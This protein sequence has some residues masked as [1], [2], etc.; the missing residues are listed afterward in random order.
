V[1]LLLFDLVLTVRLNVSV[2]VESMHKH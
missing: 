1:L 2:A